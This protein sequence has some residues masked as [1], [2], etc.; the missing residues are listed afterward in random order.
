MSVT[1]SIPL[2]NGVEYS[3]GDIVAASNGVPFVGISAI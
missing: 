3:W 2:I 1:T